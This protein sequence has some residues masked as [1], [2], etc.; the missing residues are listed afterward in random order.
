MP[1][2]F[3][4]ITIMLAFLFTGCSQSELE[5][6]DIG[7]FSECKQEGVKAPKWTCLSDIDGY[8]SAVG[9]ATH[10]AAGI[11]YMR[12]VA[13][14]NGRSEL[15]SQIKTN[16]KDKITIYAGTTGVAKSE[17]LDTATESIT[18]QVADVDLSN[19]KAIDIWE[20][21]SG[22]LYILVTVPK[23]SINQNI[24]T[25]LRT[26]YKNQEAL[27]QQFRAKNALDELEKEFE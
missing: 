27:W 16:V 12:K 22:A 1:K 23:D 6:Q 3:F 11:A 26:S 14:A 20:A 9:I 7:T 15:A 10:S 13:L 19:S 18:K 17:T 25:N 5:K 24:K 21:P 2:Y 4:L 8:Y